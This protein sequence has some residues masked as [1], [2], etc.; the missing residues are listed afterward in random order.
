[1]YIGVPPYEL[2]AARARRQQLEKLLEESDKQA[3]ELQKAKDE[4]DGEISCLESCPGANPSPKSPQPTLPDSQ[5]QLE[6]TIPATDVELAQSLHGG[7]MEKAGEHVEHEGAPKDVECEDA[8][9]PVATPTRAL[10]KK[11]L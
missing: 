2:Q 11:N 9:K 6:D 3:A 8:P 1:M 4:A 7:P 10:Y 5:S